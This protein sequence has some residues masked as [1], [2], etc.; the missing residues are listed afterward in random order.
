MNKRIRNK[1]LKHKTLEHDSMTAAASELS[2]RDLGEQTAK[3]AVNEV[4]TQAMAIEAKAEKLLEK[5]PFI[6]ETASH[7]LHDL[8]EKASA[9]VEHAM[10]PTAP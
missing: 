4:R 3:K 7:K 10:H 5:V 1:I 8:A 6:G 9:A 2:L